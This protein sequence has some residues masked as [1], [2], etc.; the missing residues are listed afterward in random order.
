MISY[1]QSAD[2]ASKRSQAERNVK[3]HIS[4]VLTN[5]AKSIALKTNTI[6]LVSGKDEF[7]AEVYKAAENDLKLA[8]R[9]IE[10]YIIEYAKASIT[11]L[12]DKDTGALTRMLNDKLFGKT[13]K[14]RNNTYMSFF[15]NDVANVLYAC[16][17]LELDNMDTQKE[18]LK[19][20]KDPYASDIINRANKKN[21]NIATPS[22]GRGIYHSA[23][24]NIVRNA[25]GT[26][27][28][29]WQ[30]ELGNYAKRNGVLFFT[31]HRG[32]SYPCP[33]CDSY[34]ERA[35]PIDTWD[36]NAPLYHSRC[37]CWVTFT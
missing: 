37:R 29:A 19:Y 21:A 11:V 30:K 35:F 16:R 23:Y 9:I 28:V 22:Y 4:D 34:A 31:P 36:E 13:F 14:Q 24:E 27:A 7:K 1:Q 2:Y 32:S 8:N 25:Q 33:L 26:I 10:N 18:L 12:G 20:F 15:S 3:D 5:T 17:V 6:K